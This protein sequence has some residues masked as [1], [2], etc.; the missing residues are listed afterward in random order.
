[1]TRFAK[2]VATCHR[3]AIIR[4]LRTSDK[5]ESKF[6]QYTYIAQIFVFGATEADYLI[7]RVSS[8]VSSET[9]AY[10]AMNRPYSPETNK[11][12]TE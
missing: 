7:V 10:A 1:M 6:L 12:F 2:A 5:R 8:V 3:P 11:Q 9:V 4:I